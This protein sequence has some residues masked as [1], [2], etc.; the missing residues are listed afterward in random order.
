MT[1]GIS[2]SAHHYPPV[3]GLT[4]GYILSPAARARVSIGA[5]TPGSRTHRGLHS[6]A[7][8]AGSRLYWCD[9]PRFADSP[10]ATFCRPLCGLASLL[11]RLPPVR[12]LTGGYI[13]SPAARACVSIG[14]TTP[15]S[16][17]H[18]GLHPVARCPGLRAYWCDYPRVAGSPGG[19]VLSPAA[20]ARVS[21]GATTPGSRTHRGLHSVARCA[22]SSL[23][24]KPLGVDTRHSAL[25][26]RHSA[27]G[28]RH[29]ALGTQ[30]SAECNRD[31]TTGVSFTYNNRWDNLNTPMKT[32]LIIALVVGCATSMAA[33]TNQT[34]SWHD[35]VRDVY[36]DNELD[37]TAQFLVSDNP[38]RAAIIC[39]KL[40]KAIV[41]DIDSHTVN[42]IP[43]DKFKFSADRAEATSDGAYEKAGKFTRI[44]GPVYSFAIDGKP[45]LIRPHTGETGVMNQTKLWEIVPVWKALMDNY[46]PDP[47]TVEALK[48]VDKDTD[49]TL[50]FGTWCGDSRHY[51]PQVMRALTEAGNNKLH[52]KL[53]G[54]DTQFRQPSDTVQPL[55]LTNVPTIIVERGGKE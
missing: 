27:L 11:V 33:Q 38:S 12:G 16:R 13:L 37:R 19:S 34:I 15:G 43:K 35:S 30:R 2:S 24:S 4:G 21:I 8:C 50:L 23:V 18:R 36:I 48:S 54:I 39:S 17:T 26:T 45:V 6:V 31:P 1:T 7:R 46:K 49:V 28:T 10:G 20:R 22:G 51:I 9:Y 29:S 44:D 14:A 3:R 32:I 53:I 47:S 41:L 5:T 42:I 40:N 25:G 55:H 52:L